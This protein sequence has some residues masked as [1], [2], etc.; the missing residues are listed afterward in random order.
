MSRTPITVNTLTPNASTA[1]T[2]TTIDV[3]NDHTV[4]VAE[5]ERLTLLVTNTD[6]ANHTVTVRGGDPVTGLGASHDVQ[7]SVPAGQTRLLGPFDSTISQQRDGSL[8][9]DFETGH[10]GAVTAILTPRVV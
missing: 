7:F 9:V 10:A 8:A 3:V 4:K 6:S 2:S 1:L 5:V